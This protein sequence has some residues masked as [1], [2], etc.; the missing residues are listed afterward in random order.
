M[1]GHKLFGYTQSALV[2]AHWQGQ[3]APTAR[4]VQYTVHLR[5]AGYYNG[6]TVNATEDT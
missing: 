2:V 5:L 3:L 4:A 6:C 1:A